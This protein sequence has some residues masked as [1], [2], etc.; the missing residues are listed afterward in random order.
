MA[1][2]A[3]TENSQHSVVEN[4]VQFQN[5]NYKLRHGEAYKSYQLVRKVIL[6][7]DILIRHQVQSELLWRLL[8]PHSHYLSAQRQ[9]R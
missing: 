2:R 3:L 1:S 5:R 4:A 9:E 7:V 8:A 6:S